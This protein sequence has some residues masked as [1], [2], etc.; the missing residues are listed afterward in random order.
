MSI[1]R[2]G[3]LGLIMVGLLISCAPP[4]TTP[5][6]PGQGS[7][8]ALAAKKRA[9]AAINGQPFAL[10]YAISSGGAFTPP[11]SE[12]LEE[13]VH[14]GLTSED[15]RGAQIPRLAEAVPTLDNGLL[16]TFPD[17]RMETTWHIKPNVQWHDGIP[18][19]ADD[20]LFTMQVVKDPDVTVF[21]NRAFDLITDVKA[22]DP[23]TIVVSWSKP[24][25]DAH[26]LFSSVGLLAMP[27]PKH[28]LQPAYQTKKSEYDSLPFWTDEFVGLGPFKLKT[29]ERDQ[30]MVVT[31]NDQYV[32]GRPKLDEIEIRFI[33]D[34]KTAASSVLADAVDFTLGRGLSLD[35]AL[36]VG[37]QWK[38]GHVESAPYS[39]LQ[40]WPQ[41]VDPRPSVMTDPQFRRA[42]TYATERQQLVDVFMHGQG[43]VAQ[44]YMRPTD[45]G[46]ADIDTTSVVK[47]NYDPQKATQIIQELG[48]TRGADGIFVD[49]SGQKLNVQLKANA[50]DDLREKLVPVIADQ[51][52]KAGVDVEQFIVPTQRQRDF[53]FISTFPGWWMTQRPNGLGRLDNLYSEQAPLPANGYTGS[54]IS[55]FQSREFDALL[56][57]YFQSPA[58]PQ[59]T[60]AAKQ[61]IHILTDQAI[62][63]GLF[64]TVESVLVNNHITNVHP[65]APD[66]THAWN[67]E[68]WDIA[69]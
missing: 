61:M 43:G 31:A 37:D 18:F 3:G 48:Y 5:Q 28:I 7:P 63:M 10:S 65:R 38:E 50:G 36:Q 45:E 2:F 35:F 24:F 39:W 22:P 69:S 56:D 9:V 51:W 13:I 20:L 4:A 19:T 42:L 17:G 12:A 15:N 34:I 68:Q 54:N 14:T 52:Q 1:K 44:S 59:R 62:I 27:Q 33:P 32:M 49:R 60:E 58:A 53:E 23:R 26:R 67:A 11:G 21:R 40:L 64:Y 47:Y 25:I 57:R 8:A 41:L 6:T 30:F 66:A 16:K 46:F 29:F 55:R